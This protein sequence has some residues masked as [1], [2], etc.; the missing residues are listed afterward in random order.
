MSRLV[1]PLSAPKY[2]G[3][4]HP[5]LYIITQLQITSIP[6]KMKLTYDKGMTVHTIAQKMAKDSKKWI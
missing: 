3:E 1:L 5:G 4:M 6:R 2:L